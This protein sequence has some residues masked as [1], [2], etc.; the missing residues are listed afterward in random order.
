MR[1]GITRGIT[2]VARSKQGF[3][4]VLKAKRARY[5]L[6]RPRST[7]RSNSSKARC[8]KDQEE[9]R[10]GEQESLHQQHDN[11][12]EHEDMDTR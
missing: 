2:G 6:T 5:Q 8:L 7:R 10:L 1:R 11:R 9:Q 3:D 4:E 12:V